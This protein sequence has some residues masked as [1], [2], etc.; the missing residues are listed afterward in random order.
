MMGKTKNAYVVALIGRSLLAGRA[1]ITSYPR[2][3]LHPLSISKGNITG[4]SFN[5]YSGNFMP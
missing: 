2:R 5:Y 4:T 1:T 3:N